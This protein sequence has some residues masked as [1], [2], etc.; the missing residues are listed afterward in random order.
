M[1]SQ[2]IQDRETRLVGW[3]RIASHLG[4]GERTARR[5]EREEKLPVHRQQHAAQATVYAHASELDAWLASRTEAGASAPSASHRFNHRFAVIGAIAICLGLIGIMGWRSID[6]GPQAVI[7]GSNDPVAVDLYERGR[8]LWLQRGKEP[9]TRAVKLFEEAVA[10]DE[11]Y[12]EAWEALA[13][14]WLTLPSY[15]DE[16]D[17][18]RAFNEALYA[19]DRAVRLNPNLAEARSVMAAV[20]Q[21]RADW[22]ESKRIFEDALLQDPD[23][24]MLMLWLAE[25]HR[26]LGHIETAKAVLREALEMSP[27]SP[28]I[29]TGL[30]MN[31][32]VNLDPSFAKGMLETLWDGMGF[33]TVDVWYG[34]WHLKLRAGD[35]DAAMD[36][37][38]QAPPPMNRDMLAAFTVAKRDRNP[39]QLNEVRSAIA[40]AYDQGLP[41]WLAYSL[42]DHL[43]AAEI[44]QQIARREVANGRFYLSVV[45]FDP[46]FPDGRQTEEF[47]AIV[48]DL[49]YLDYWK[50]YGAPDFCAERPQPPICI[51][52][53]D[54]NSVTP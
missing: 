16:A 14:A 47:A 11:N 46:M 26:D 19:A 3:K 1:T 28:P 49:G 35:Y 2:E 22:A 41:A 50:A 7:S 37:L 4:C 52:L 54:Q 33:E 53:P 48:T 39:D 24:V 6:P 25:H 30:A 42:L 13:G 8:A 23:N 9:N 44:G 18:T 21:R 10:R 5:W 27:S 12:A 17:S 51:G 20:A 29:M 15:S 31:S 38:L 45:M 43:E 34:L 36:W 40:A 32:H